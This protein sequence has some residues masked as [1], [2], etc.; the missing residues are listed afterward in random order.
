MYLERILILCLRGSY[1]VASPA[2]FRLP[3]CRPPTRAALVAMPLAPPAAPLAAVA[4]A[5]GRHL[6][7]LLLHEARAV[8]ARVRADAP[9]ELAEEHVLKEGCVA[10]VGAVAAAANLDLVRVRAEMAPMHVV[11]RRR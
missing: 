7:L 3:V 4:A 6:L 8:P 11:P 10:K 9:A 1:T 2:F 5:L